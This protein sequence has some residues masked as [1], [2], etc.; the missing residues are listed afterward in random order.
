M[1][2]GHAWPAGLGHKVEHS[3]VRDVLEHRR[4]E[5]LGGFQLVD[6]VY[7]QQV[8]SRGNYQYVSG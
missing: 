2:L 4:A 8:E 5:R 1:Q 3:I 7:D 6:E